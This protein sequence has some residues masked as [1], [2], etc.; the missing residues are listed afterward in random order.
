MKPF[1]SLLPNQ[2]ADRNTRFFEFDISC[3]LI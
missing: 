1:L 2:A 3:P